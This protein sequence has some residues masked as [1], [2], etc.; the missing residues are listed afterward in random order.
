MPLYCLSQEANTMVLAGL[1]DVVYDF[2]HALMAKLPPS[3]P[4]PDHS[5]PPTRKTKLSL[6]IL[7]SLI[8]LR[9][10][11]GHRSWKDYYRYLEAHPNG[12]NVGLLAIYK[13]FMRSVHKLTG[14][15]VVFLEV[16]RK[17]SK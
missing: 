15:A 9:F 5:Q 17:R 6:V 10:A 8:R 1:Y 4:V 13:K 11:T 7:V 14:Y 12:V 3:L 2:H 16:L